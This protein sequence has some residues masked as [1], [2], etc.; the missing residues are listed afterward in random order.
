MNGTISPLSPR[1]MNG[2]ISPQQQPPQ[3]QPRT[4][5]PIVQTITPDA[6]LRENW[7]R[8]PPVGN[9]APRNLGLV[10]AEEAE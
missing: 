5:S 1:P 2:T 3:Q 8:T 6:P 10:F 9:L 4:P 7:H